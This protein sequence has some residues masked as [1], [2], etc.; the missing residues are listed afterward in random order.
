M[1]VELYRY[2]GGLDLVI[3]GLSVII[4]GLD[5]AR[6]YFNATNDKDRVF[7]I[8][9][10]WELALEHK[11]VPNHIQPEYELSVEQVYTKAS[12][13]TIREMPNLN[14]PSLVEYSSIPKPLELQELPELP[15]WFPIIA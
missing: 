14:L 2:N 12:W 7:A 6:P 1:V 8:L 5:I 3:V 11:E 13:A 15:S 9:G 10:L 4:V